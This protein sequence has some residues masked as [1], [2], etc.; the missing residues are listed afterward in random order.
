[1]RRNEKPCVCN[2]FATP[3]SKNPVKS[4]VPSSLNDNHTFRNVQFQKEFFDLSGLRSWEVFG[5]YFGSVS[6]FGV[7]FLGNLP[8]YCILS[9]FYVFKFY[10][11]IRT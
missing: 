6:S 4:S 2:V 3:H 7:G 8:Y 10:T 5:V 1:M 9:L 11:Y